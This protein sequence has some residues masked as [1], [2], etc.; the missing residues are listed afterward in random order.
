MT[1]MANLKSAFNNLLG[2]GRAEQELQEELGQHI[3]TR[4]EQLQAGGLSAAEAERQARMEFGNTE[5]FKEECRE[6]RGGFWLETF[7]GDVRFGLR[8]LRKSPGFTFVAILTLA[9]GIGANTAI[10]TMANGLMLHT[11]PVHEP[12]QL[13]EL[14]EHYPGDPEPGF[15]AFS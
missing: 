4:A 6:E 9:L 14:L 15:N 2:H 10:F 3:R 12:G 11:L 13:V 5:K 8:M 1:F 7:W